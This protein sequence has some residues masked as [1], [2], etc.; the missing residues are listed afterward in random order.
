V[1]VSV[2][3]TAAC[4]VDVAVSD[5]VAEEANEKEHGVSEPEVA[6]GSI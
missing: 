3:F 6:I 5:G 4:A 2:A 1:S